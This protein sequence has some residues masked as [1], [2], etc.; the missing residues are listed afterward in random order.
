MSRGLYTT[1]IMAGTYPTFTVQAG[2]RVVVRSIDVSLAPAG[3]TVGLIAPGLGEITGAA[4]SIGSWHW[5]GEQAFDAGEGLS[6]AGEGYLL[7]T[8][9]VLSAP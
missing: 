3:A 1:R 6:Y 5:R 9:W 7:V 4:D 2:T 8:G